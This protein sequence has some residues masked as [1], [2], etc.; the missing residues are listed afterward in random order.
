MA[1][2]WGIFFWQALADLAKMVAQVIEF[3]GD[4]L[5]A[6]ELIVGVALAGDELSA[7]FRGGQTAIQAGGAE[8][9]VGLDVVLD[10]IAD[11]VEQA[12]EMELDRL[13]SA[14][15][16]GILASDPGTAFL[17]GLAKGIASPAEQ[18]EGLALPQTKC[19]HGVGH[20][21][22]AG[23]PPGKTV[24]GT[25]NQVSYFRS[26]FHDITSCQG[27]EVL[28]KDHWTRLFFERT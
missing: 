1:F 5:Q 9:R 7:D 21:T 15:G 11:I 26:K 4:G 12:G 13:A 19:G 20:V 2:V 22:A 23:W 25:T 14:T 16:G 8:S 10:K 18:E 28:Y 6:G 27:L 3:A 17:Q 24:S